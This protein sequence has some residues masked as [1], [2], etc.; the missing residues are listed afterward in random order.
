MEWFGQ[1]LWKLEAALGVPVILL[2]LWLRNSG[3]RRKAVKWWMQFCS[4]ACLA[5]HFS[6]S[7]P[8]HKEQKQFLY[9]ELLALLRTSIP[10]EKKSQFCKKIHIPLDKLIYSPHVCSTLGLFIPMLLILQGMGNSS[11]GSFSFCLVEGGRGMQIQWF[12]FCLELLSGWKKE[13]LPL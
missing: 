3:R 4:R 10:A 12:D 5:L 8:N 9:V 13:P 7:F 1:V 11:C 2:P 6:S